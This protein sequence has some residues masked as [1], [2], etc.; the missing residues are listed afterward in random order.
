MNPKTIAVAN[1]ALAALCRQHHIRR[2]ALF[3]SAL[4]GKLRTKSDVDLLVEFEP[5]HIPGFL[6]LARIAGEM[7][8]LF[9]GR[10]I[11]LRTPN[12][13]SRYFRDEV[14]REAAPLYERT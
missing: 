12:D 7:S 5:G 3:G 8:V 1:D 14:L 9:E 2:L 10:P 13:L 4:K 6:G 11:D